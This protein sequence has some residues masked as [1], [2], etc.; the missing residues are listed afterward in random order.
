MA[1]VLFVLALLLPATLGAL[2]TGNCLNATLPGILNLG[3]CFGTS[4]NFCSTSA[5]GLVTALTK[6]LTCLATPLTSTS[7]I[8]GVTAFTDII[9]IVLRSLGL[10]TFLGGFQSALTPLCALGGS[11]VV[12]GC[13]TLLT[14]NQTCSS[15]IS[16]S[17]PDAFGLSRCLNQT[18]NVC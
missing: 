18:L 12:P 2:P 16:I 11:T 7:G 1:P 17:L 5:S 14:G 8:G 9:T 13:A 6:L 15:P 4:L 3:Q 10:G